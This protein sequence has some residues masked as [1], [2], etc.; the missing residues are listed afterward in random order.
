MDVKSSRIFD[1]GKNSEI[2]VLRLAE[3]EK[4]SGRDRLNSRVS[5]E[6]LSRGTSS[7][8][9]TVVAVNAYDACINA[10]LLR[11]HQSGGITRTP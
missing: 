7:I 8:F 3:H 4:G 6:W 10:G 11:T 9:I 5:K 1:S 2:W